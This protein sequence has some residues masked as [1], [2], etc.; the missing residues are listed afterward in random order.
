[1]SDLSV[2]KFAALTVSLFAAFAISCASKKKADDQAGGLDGGAG[3]GDV[4]ISQEP[5]NFNPQGSDS[6]QINGLTTVNFPYDSSTLDGRAR[7]TLKAN[8]SWMGQN[9]KVSVQ[10]E[11]HCDMRGSVE[12]NLAL[13]ER[14]AKAVKDYMVGLGADEKR[15]SIVS[16]GKEKM[17]DLGDTESAHAKNRRANFVPL[18]N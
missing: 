3:S 13:G 10:I 2:K 9:A 18:S 4:T 1:V 14:R 12:Y 8:T 11:G 15:L 5:M 7:E 16:Y 17:I 6:G